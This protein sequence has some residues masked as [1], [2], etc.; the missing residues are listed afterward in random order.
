MRRAFA[1]CLLVAT[2]SAVSFA[3]VPLNSERSDW[4]VPA[5]AWWA[6]VQYLADDKLEGR[7]TGTPGYDKAVAYVVDQFKAIGLKPAGT[8]GYLQP[9]DFQ[10]VS[11]DMAK[12]SAV[13][14]V[15]GV[16]TP[17]A[18]GTDLTLTPGLTTDSVNA[19]M[20]FIG[21]GLRIPSKHRNDYTDEDVRGKIAVFY[22]APPVDLLGNQRA[23]GRGNDQRW[24]SLRAAGAVGMIQIAMPRPGA[25][26][27]RGVGRPPSAL[28]FADPSLDSLAGIQIVGTL[29]PT[30]AAK[31]FAGTGHTL[32]ELTALAI[33]GKPLPHF[34]IAGTLTASAVPT[35]GAAFHAPN[36]IGMIEGSD[37]KLKSEYVVVSAHLDHLG[38]QGDG[39]GD[40]IF[41]GAMD[42]ASGVASV[43][44]C[45]KLIAASKV[46]PKRSILFITLA[47]EELGEL[48]SSYFARKPS[49]LKQNV[50]G[51]LNMDMYMPLFPLRYIQVQGMAE[52]TL[53]NDA[54][55]TF[56]LNDVEVQF[57]LQAEENRFVRSDQVNFVKQGIPAIAFKFGWVPDSPEMKIYNDWVAT[58]YHKASDDL[59]QPVDKVAAAQFTGVLAQLM[60]RVANA[61]DRPAWYPESSFATA[62]K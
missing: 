41:N 34:P 48:G 19:S 23:Y 1:A 39:P 24:K 20:V 13:L 43:I 47:A 53:G 54:R 61:K 31:L 57:D 4:S 30:G 50:V 44:E 7:R 58:R 45:A 26:A 55:A 27:P 11:L 12:S 25:A 46:R 15:N 42:N 21:Y 28:L 51:D 52:S 37:P 2:L 29:T 56:Q 5:A 33:P 49:V 14:K 3:Q 22:N 9:I 36:V 40:H 17:L 59:D 32:D 38:V 35:L 8:Q 6:H 16:E 62:S 18:L 10:P 60:L